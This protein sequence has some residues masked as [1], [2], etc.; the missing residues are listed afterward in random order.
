MFLHHFSVS[1]EL[2]NGFIFTCVS[3]SAS[4]A[5]WFTATQNYMY[6]IRITI[7]MYKN[8]SFEVLVKPFVIAAEM[9]LCYIDVCINYSNTKLT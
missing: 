6:A 9:T 1:T 3:A 5:S 7:C 8:L 2:Y 4:M